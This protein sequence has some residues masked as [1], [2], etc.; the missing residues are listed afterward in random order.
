MRGSADSPQCRQGAMRTAS[1]RIEHVDG[2]S[3]AN[4]VGG[5]GSGT[6]TIC[7][8]S[9]AIASNGGWSLTSIDAYSAVIL[10]VVLIPALVASAGTASAYPVQW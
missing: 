5:H 4:Q 7:N 9:R 8:P 6:C 1:A 10:V 2:D 3:N